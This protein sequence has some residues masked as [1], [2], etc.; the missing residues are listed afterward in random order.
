MIIDVEARLTV[1]TKRAEEELVSSVAH[2]L[3]G[4]EEG[5][6]ILFFLIC[7]MGRCKLPGVS[8]PSLA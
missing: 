8:Y 4:R 3:V 1:K 5:V 2:V 7:H 6:N